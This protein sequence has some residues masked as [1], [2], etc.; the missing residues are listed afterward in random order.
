M[1]F[2]EVPVDFRVL[3]LLQNKLQVSSKTTEV[4]IKMWALWNPNNEIFTYK[5]SENDDSLIFTSLI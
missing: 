4:E 2:I 5:V 1:H 3:F